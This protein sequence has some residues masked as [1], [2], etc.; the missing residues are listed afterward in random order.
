MLGIGLAFKRLFLSNKCCWR[1][2]YIIMIVFCI[3]LWLLLLLFFDE[4]AEIPD[5]FERPREQHSK[6]WD[7]KLP[8][9][10]I[11]W[12]RLHALHFKYM[13][14][15]TNQIMILWVTCVLY[16]I[17]LY[18]FYKISKDNYYKTLFLTNFSH[19]IKYSIGLL[20]KWYK[21]IS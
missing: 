20:N 18:Y 6:H 2:K 21:R 19:T 7:G 14:V 5:S 3:G 15:F 8:C 17:F 9:Y 16:Y 11:K 1:C 12:I 10:W 13:D 4:Q